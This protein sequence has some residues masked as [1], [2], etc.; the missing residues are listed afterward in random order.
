[1][2]ARI[3]LVA[4]NL[5]LLRADIDEARRIAAAIRRP[6]LRA[7][8]LQVGHRVQVSCNLTDPIRL[9]PAE[10]YELVSARAP[11]A[12]AEVVGLVPES[13]LALVPRERWPGLDL[14]P[15]R[16]IETRLAAGH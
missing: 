3:P 14:D 9:G 10:A 12:G 6:G 1:V 13:V 7:L 5:W 2:G 11:V 15:D 16:T 8:G 4:Y